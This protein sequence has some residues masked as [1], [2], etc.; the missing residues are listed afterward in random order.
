MQVVLIIPDAVGECEFGDG[1]DAEGLHDQLGL[2]PSVH[3][4][5]LLLLGLQQVAT[6]AQNRLQGA[7]TP[8]VVLLGR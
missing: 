1:V 2:Q 5:S 6:A 3:L 7:Q 4:L 8:V